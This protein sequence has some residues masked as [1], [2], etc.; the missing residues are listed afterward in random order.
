M[1]IAFRQ[2][3]DFG[4]PLM[5]RFLAIALQ[6]ALMKYL[7]SILYPTDYAAWVE[8]ISWFSLVFLFEGVLIQSYRNSI[9]DHIRDNK[10]SFETFTLMLRG[11]WLISIAIF[12]PLAIVIHCKV[13]ITHAMPF[14]VM[15][16]LMQVPLKAATFHKN[17]SYLNQN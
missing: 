12:L 11:L 5:A 6:L 10:A 17:K 15:L 1:N 14:Y 13:G 2:S 7:T 9:S 8:F 4:L 3:K 16:Y